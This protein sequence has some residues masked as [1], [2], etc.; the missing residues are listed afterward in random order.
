VKH[1]GC[2][3]NRGTMNKSFHDVSSLFVLAERTTSQRKLRARPAKRL[4][5]N[6]CAEFSWQ[7]FLEVV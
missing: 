4:P 7:I 2:G 6:Q 3:E 5:A 1:E